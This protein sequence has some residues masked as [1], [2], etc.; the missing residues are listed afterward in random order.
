MG[1][2][3]RSYRLTTKATVRAAM[4]KEGLFLKNLTFRKIDLDQPILPKLNIGIRLISKQGSTDHG[5]SSG[6][7]SLSRTTIKSIPHYSEGDLAA[8]KFHTV[9]QASTDRNQLV[10]FPNTQYVRIPIIS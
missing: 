10:A 6:R 8:C 9:N 3:G 2:S 4:I 5:H 7:S 1:L